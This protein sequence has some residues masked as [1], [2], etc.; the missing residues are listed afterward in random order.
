MRHMAGKTKVVHV[1]MPLPL[2]EKIDGLVAGSG[3]KDSRARFIA[4]AVEERVKR[5][6]YLR[7]VERLAGSL[8]AEEVP[9]WRDDAA[10]AAWLEDNRR[11]DLESSEEKWRR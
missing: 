1:R 9:H 7:A 5:E 8:S 10:L 4:K 3:G 11:A 2:L 6:Q